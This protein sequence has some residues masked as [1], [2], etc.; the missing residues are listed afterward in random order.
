MGGGF[1]RSLKPGGACS[2][3]SVAICIIE[4]RDPSILEFVLGPTAILAPHRVFGG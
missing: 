3:L 1:F 2:V 4:K